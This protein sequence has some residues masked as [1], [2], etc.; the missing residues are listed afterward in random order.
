MVFLLCAL[1]LSVFSGISFA[2]TEKGSLK[3]KLTFGV[4]LNDASQEIVSNIEEDGQEIINTNQGKVLITKS[5][6][7]RIS[8]KDKKGNSVKTVSTDESGV[9]NVTDLSQGKYVLEIGAGNNQTF[10]SEEIQIQKDT[11]EYNKDVYVTLDQLLAS[12]HPSEDE[13][14]DH[15]MNGEI[16]TQS[17]LPPNLLCLD[18]NGTN[19][20][21]RHVHDWDHFYNSDCYHSYVVYGYT[22]RCAFD[23]N[24]SLEFCD[25]T[26]NCSYRIGHSSTYHTHPY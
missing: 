9:F 16:G 10:L 24:D 12:M 15:S 5:S 23:H 2:K 20:D 26:K 25:G 17:H 3:G 7:L 13:D 18:Y 1:V 8:L 4:F 11:L 14:H 21:G 22:P 19:T 6:F